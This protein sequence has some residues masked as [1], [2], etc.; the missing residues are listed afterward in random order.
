MFEFRDRNFET[1]YCV[2]LCDNYKIR[3]P[4]SACNKQKKKRSEG[5][6]MWGRRTNEIRERA[7]WEMSAYQNNIQICQTVL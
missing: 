2:K 4:L 5:K 3:K 7:V 6:G 1:V